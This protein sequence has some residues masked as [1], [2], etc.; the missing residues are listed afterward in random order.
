MRRQPSKCM[1]AFDLRQTCTD[2]PLLCSLHSLQCP[3]RLWE[4]APRGKE[5]QAG[6]AR[7]GMVAWAGEAV[8]VASMEAEV[9]VATALALAVPE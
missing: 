2:Q 5:R 4:V 1:H 7:K 3:H 6:E 9:Q 8:E